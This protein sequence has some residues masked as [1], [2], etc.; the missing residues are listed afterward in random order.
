MKS[1]YTQRDLLALSNEQ[2]TKL[3]K[4]KTICVVLKDG[5]TMVICVFTILLAYPQNLFCGFKAK[6][7]GVIDLVQIDYIEI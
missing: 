5:S 3:T 7:N 6:D 4:G 2:I 1:V